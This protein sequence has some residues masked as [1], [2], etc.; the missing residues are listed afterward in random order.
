VEKKAPPVY[1]LSMHTCF[2]EAAHAFMAWTLNIHFLKIVA[3]SKPDREQDPHV[4]FEMTTPA[5][6]QKIID[7]GISEGPKTYRARKLIEKRMMVCLAGNIANLRLFGSHVM[8]E[9]DTGVLSYKRIKGLYTE[10]G[11][12]PDF[13]TAERLAS[14]IY[15]DRAVLETYIIWLFHR[16]KAFIESPDSWYMVQELADH[17]DDFTTIDWEHAN[18]A[19]KIARKRL[20]ERKKKKLSKT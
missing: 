10:N 2:H 3:D 15:E 14:I 16:V 1:P 11:G 8:K 9:E 4:R 13:D 19:L 6:I 20:K 7:R 12:E 5:N 18:R 17:L